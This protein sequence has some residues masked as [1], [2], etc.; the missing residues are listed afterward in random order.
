MKALFLLLTFVFQVALAE[1]TENPVTAMGP[2]TV[3]ESAI[4]VAS[5]ESTKPEKVQAESEI[6]LNI[7]AKKEAVTKEGF[8]G[9]LISSL[10]VILLLGGGILYL[11]RKYSIPRNNSVHAQIKIL[12]QHHFGPKRSLALIRVAGE[13]MLIGITDNQINLVK[14]LSLLDE[15][16]P[17]DVPKS[18]SNTLSQKTEVEDEP[19]VAS[20]EDFAIS[21]IKDIVHKKLRGMRSFQ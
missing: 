14:S 19:P 6:P 13:S 9:K 1:T 2:S 7:E 15:D 4:P 8:A 5:T 3:V 10:V 20:E 21:G 18:F 12:S 11:V 17:E 16:V